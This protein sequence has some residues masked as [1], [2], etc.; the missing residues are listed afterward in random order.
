VLNVRSLQGD[1]IY[2]YLLYALPQ[3]ARR[4]DGRLRDGYLQRY[5][6]ITGAW[7]S[8]GLDPLNNWLPMTW[9]RAKPDIPRLEWDETLGQ[10]NNS[11][12]FP[13]SSPK[14]IKYESPP[15]TPNR[16]TYLRISLASQI[17]TQCDS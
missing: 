3:T 2:E 16:V 4:N 11:R 12:P 10:E 1:E 8:S 9:G 17:Q 5:A 13:K 14:P 6:D 15:K 7:W